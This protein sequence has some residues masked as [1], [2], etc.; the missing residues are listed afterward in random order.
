[1]KQVLT[2]CLKL[3]KVERKKFTLISGHF[4]SSPTQQSFLGEQVICT[5]RLDTNTQSDANFRNT[6]LSRTYK[7]KLNRLLLLLCC[8]YF[9]YYYFS[10]P[11]FPSVSELDIFSDVELC[12]GIRIVAVSKLWNT[13]I[14][15]YPI[16]KFA[17]WEDTM[18]FENYEYK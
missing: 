15:R 11:L 13:I 1:M 18:L 8:Y 17:L 4:P 6:I 7:Q 14:N 2:I 5:Y 12:L 9:Y 10:L 3:W 16:A